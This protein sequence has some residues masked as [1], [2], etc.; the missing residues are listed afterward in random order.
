MINYSTDKNILVHVTKTH[1]YETLP[2]ALPI[3]VNKFHP[4]KGHE[5]PEG[6]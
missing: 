3:N 6:K 4:R 5:V 2:M 1:L